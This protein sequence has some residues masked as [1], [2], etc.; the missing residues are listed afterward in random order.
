MPKLACDICAPDIERFYDTSYD[1]VESNQ[2]L[3]KLAGASGGRYL[4]PGRVVV[5]RD[6]VSSRYSFA[7]G[8]TELPSDGLIA[9]PV[10]SRCPPPEGFSYRY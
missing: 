5:L 3:L 10:K 6:R 2:K 7:I 4:E 8:R 9:L 1:I